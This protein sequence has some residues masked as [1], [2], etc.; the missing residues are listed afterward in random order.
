MLRLLQTQ[1]GYEGCNG[2]PLPET[3]RSTIAGKDP[4]D[5][6]N[7]LKLTT[8]AFPTKTAQTT[9]VAPQSVHLSLFFAEPPALRA[10]STRPQS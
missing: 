5:L 3:I 7:T 2:P 1:V 10:L 4:L 9:Q 6:K 8:L